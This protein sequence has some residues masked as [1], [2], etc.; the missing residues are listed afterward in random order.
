MSTRLADQLKLKREPLSKPLPVQLAVSGSRSVINYN[1]KVDFNYQDIKERRTFNIINIDSYDLILRTPF[2]FQ[3]KILMGFNPYQVAI[4]S[5]AALPIEGDQI[6]HV[7]SRATDLLEADFEKLC[8][9]LREYAKD[10]CKDAIE[11]PLPPLR[12]INHTIPLIDEAKI[13]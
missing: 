4:G 2:L 13:Y 5:T 6:C 3:H 9:E 12:D 10:I 7:S 11:T 1:T 8:D